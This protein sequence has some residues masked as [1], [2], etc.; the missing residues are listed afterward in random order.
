MPAGL[1]P[2][3]IPIAPCGGSGATT[4][5]AGAAFFALPI[6]FGTPARR[7]PSRSRV[8]LRV[9]PFGFSAVAIARQSCTA[10]SSTGT[11]FPCPPGSTRRAQRALHPP[12]GTTRSSDFCWAIGHRPFVLGPTGQLAGTQQ[13]SLGETLRFRHDRVATTPPGTT[14]TGLRCYGPAHPA[15][16]RLTALHSR[17][18]PQRTYGLLQ[19]RP[20]GSSAA[21]TAALEPPG[22]FRAA[23]LPHRCWIPPVRAPGQD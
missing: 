11:A 20:H 15:G 13:I 10:I 14:G 1:R 18:R 7:T 5:V 9:A 19:T 17:S 12:S 16:E 4:I 22:Q 2:R 23:P 3:I 21:Q 8:L 6:A